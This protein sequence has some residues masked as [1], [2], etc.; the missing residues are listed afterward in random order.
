MPL[1][2]RPF[3]EEHSQGRLSAD[4]FLK[5]HFRASLYSMQKLD[6]EITRD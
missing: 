3:E 5:Q 2:L 1:E 4:S 6:Y